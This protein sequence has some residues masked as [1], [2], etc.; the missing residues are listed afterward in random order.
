MIGVYELSFR[1]R[2]PMNTSG[3]VALLVGAA[4]AVFGLLRLVDT[5]GATNNWIYG[6]VVAIG[7]LIGILGLGYWRFDPNP[8]RGSL[9]FDGA[10]I[11]MLLIGLARSQSVRLRPSSSI[12]THRM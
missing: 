8:D 2:S 4:V 12:H 10:T 1:R 5:D 7:V 6:A 9:S 3:L 11:R